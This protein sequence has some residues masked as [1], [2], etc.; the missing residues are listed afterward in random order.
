MCRTPPI[1]C[2]G[3]MIEN[4]KGPQTLSLGSEDTVPPSDTRNQRGSI[5][6]APWCMTM[7]TGH[8]GSRRR[9]SPPASIRRGC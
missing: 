1:G 9:I 8:A 2:A 7:L 3:S 6:A 5:S 4:A